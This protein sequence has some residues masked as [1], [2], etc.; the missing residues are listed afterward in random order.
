MIVDGPPCSTDSAAGCSRS[1]VVLSC[2]VAFD[3]VEEFDSSMVGAPGLI[4]R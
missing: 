3:M 1:S 2:E 4:I